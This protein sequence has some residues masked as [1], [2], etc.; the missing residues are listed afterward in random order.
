MSSQRAGET[1]VVA[2]SAQFSQ[3]GA[4][5]AT[6]A[7]HPDGH[8][9]ISMPRRLMEPLSRTDHVVL[10]N[11]DPPRS[12]RT[13]LAQSL[14]VGSRSDTASGQYGVAGFGVL[15]WSSGRIIST[16]VTR[17]VPSVFSILSLRSRKPKPAGRRSDLSRDQ[18][19]TRAPSSLRSQVQFVSP[20]VAGKVLT[21]DALASRTPRLVSD[22]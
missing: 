2:A 18:S 3:L 13:A 17:E 6:A 8:P 12:E 15:L 4:D 11:G 9:V 20:D 10:I 1:L 22:L 5:P 21:G 7:V 19:R 14:P 16:R